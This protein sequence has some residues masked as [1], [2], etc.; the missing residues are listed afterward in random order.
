MKHSRKACGRSGGFTLIE[1]LIV[2][3]IIGILATIAIPA[4]L[5]QRER[6][7]ESAVKGGIHNIELGIASYGVDHDDTYPATGAVSRASLVDSAGVPYVDNWPENPWRGGDMTDGTSPG[8]YVYSSDTTE[9]TIVGL[10]RDGTSII[11][12]P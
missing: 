6:A 2:V 5:A 8:D 4:Y 3:I 10:G 1:M 12:A 9:F 7:K 11:T